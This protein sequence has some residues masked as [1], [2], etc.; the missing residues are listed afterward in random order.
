MGTFLALQQQ[1]QLYDNMSKIYEYESENVCERR[2][3][4]CGRTHLFLS[5]VLMCT[6]LHF[7]FT[8]FLLHG[9]NRGHRVQSCINTQYKM[10]TTLTI[11]L[12][13]IMNILANFA[14]VLLYIWQVLHRNL[15]F[16][17]L[18]YHNIYFSRLHTLRNI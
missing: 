12:H 18:T 4:V 11:M 9:R 15:I 10:D 16:I 3:Y 5:I 14:H 1:M 6:T 2:M 17:F 8:L 7:T 13:Y